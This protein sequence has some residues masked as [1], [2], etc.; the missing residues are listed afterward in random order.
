MIKAGKGLKA[1]AHNSRTEYSND[2]KLDTRP[3]VRYGMCYYHKIKQ[4]KGR[5]NAVYIRQDRQDRLKSQAHP[6][7][8]L[9]IIPP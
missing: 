1:R 3:R 7:P 2:H 8:L 9:P 6:L 5:Q 4:I